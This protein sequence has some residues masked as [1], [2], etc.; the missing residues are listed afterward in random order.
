MLLTIND[1]IREH[2]DSLAWRERNFEI[3]TDAVQK[4]FLVKFKPLY[5]T[6]L[7]RF[8]QRYYSTLGTDLTS[9]GAKGFIS[10]SRQELKYPENISEKESE[11]GG[12]WYWLF[13]PLRLIWWLITGIFTVFAT[14]VSFFAMIINFFGESP[15]VT[16]RRILL[17]KNQAIY[18][19]ELPAKYWAE[20]EPYIKKAADTHD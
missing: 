4:R 13:L 1:A 10:V 3:D 17:E 18:T 8:Q 15:D 12:F 19:T 9:L 2:M 20:I 6:F 5:E 7:V 14:I 16:A 11:D